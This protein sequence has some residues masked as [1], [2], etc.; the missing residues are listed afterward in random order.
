VCT[1]CST[2]CPGAAGASP[3]CGWCWPFAGHLAEPDLATLLA[4]ADVAVVPSLYEPFGMVALEVAAARTPLVVAAT[5]GLREIVEPGVTGATFPPG[6]VAGLADAV[7]TMLTD[8]VL[9]RRT[10]RAAH[11]RVTRD[12]HWS[13][14]ADRVVDCY[15]RAIEEESAL[16]SGLAAAVTRPLRAVVREGNLLA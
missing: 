8:Q 15:E 1:P 16:Q 12:L 11:R 10:V 13:Y 2:R 7:G 4:A 3:A 9:A 6:D 5:G 14:V